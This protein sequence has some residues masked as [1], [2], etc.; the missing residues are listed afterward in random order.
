MTPK[1]FSGTSEGGES[2]RRQ[3]RW[4]PRS[5]KGKSK[6]RGPLGKERTNGE[7]KGREEGALDLQF[8]S[9]RDKKRTDLILN[10]KRGNGQSGQL[11][12]KKN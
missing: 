1:K 4:R 8:G 10:P 3:N 6:R 12:L 2:S 5:V 7:G 11:S 9:G